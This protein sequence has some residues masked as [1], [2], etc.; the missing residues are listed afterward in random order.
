MKKIITIFCLFF[1]LAIKSQIFS[2]ASGPIQNNGQLSY[3]PIAVSGVTPAQ[4]DSVFGL[5]QVCFNISHPNITELDL[6]LSSPAGTFIQL[7][8]GSSSAGG[9][10]FVNTCL[11]NQAGTSITIGTAPNTGTY[12]PIGSLGRFNNGQ[13]VNGTWTLIVYDQFP[14]ANSGVLLSCSIQFGNSPARP[15]VFKS[16]NLPIVFINTSQPISDVKTIATMGIVDNSPSRNYITDPWNAYNAKA[17]INIRGSSSEGFE[18]KSY[19]FETHDAANNK[20]KVP[21]LGMPIETDWVLYSSYADKTLMRNNLSCDLFRSMGRYAPRHRNVEVVV[22][23]EYFGVYSLLEKIKKDS[24]RVNIKKLGSNDNVFPDITGGYILQIDRPN[25]AG[26]YSQFPGNSPGG[27]KFYYQY[28]YPK[29][30]SITAQQINYIQGYMNNFETVMNSSSYADPNTG[31]PQYIDVA[32]FIDYFIISELS[33]NVDASRLSTYL[34]KQNIGNGGKLYIGPVWDYDIAWHNCMWGVSFNSAG[35]GYL[36]QSDI[37]PA[38][39]W[40]IKFMQDPNFVDKLACRWNYLRSN[41]LSTANLNNYIDGQAYELGEA[42]QRNFMQWPVLGAFIYCNPQNQVGANYST[43]IADLKNWIAAR[44]AWLD[45]NINAPCAIGIR[46]NTI[47]S[48]LKIYP[49]PMQSSTTFDMTLERNSD[50]SLCITDVVG[51]EVARFINENVNQGNAKIVFERNQIPA[52]V[53]LYQLEVNS[54]IKTGKI[55]IQ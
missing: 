16:S 44:A 33:K 3:F 49:S 28:I 22:N 39:T 30:S 27:T 8:S 41:V 40:W 11:D 13:S 19:S 23:N 6:F 9:A 50:V 14:A 10:D 24:N 52:G 1:S 4:I 15:V 17:E 43:E 51:K 7:F 38:P 55:I 31:Y 12:R 47:V 54:E 26:W 42:Q 2:G 53:Y 45:A 34:Y 37:F 48:D 20:L 35:W 32:S 29:D 46:E 25:S 5:E 21:L 18:K 36:A